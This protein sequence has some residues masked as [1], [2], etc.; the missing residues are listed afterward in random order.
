MRELTLE[1]RQIVA[2]LTG[3][4]NRQIQIELDGK[5]LPV[6]SDISIKNFLLQVSADFLRK[7]HSGPGGQTFSQKC[8]EALG[9]IAEAENTKMKSARFTHNLSP[10]KVEAS[11]VTQYTKWEKA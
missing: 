10:E 2:Y 4:T 7:L 5:P 9:R 11:E 8:K 3:I 1:Q 6:P